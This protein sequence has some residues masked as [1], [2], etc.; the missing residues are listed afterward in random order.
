MIALIKKIGKMLRC[1][2]LIKTGWYYGARQDCFA[3]HLSGGIS[4]DT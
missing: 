4:L 3:K 1:E 2:T